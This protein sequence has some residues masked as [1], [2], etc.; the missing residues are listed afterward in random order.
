ME[1][2][3]LK[4]HA[5]KRVFEEN[6]ENSEA[7]FCDFVS[8]TATDDY[9]TLSFYQTRP[10]LDPTDIQVSKCVLESRIVLTWN[11]FEKTFQN[12]SGLIES[13]KHRELE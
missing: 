13:R 12:F 11:L 7:K 10:P 9:V 2:I 8:I 6:P 3:E 1:N 4:K 5:I